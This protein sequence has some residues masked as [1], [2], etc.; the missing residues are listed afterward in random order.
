MK[1][2]FETNTYKRLLELANENNVSIPALANILLTTLLQTDSKN[3]MFYET[4]WHQV[5]RKEG[6]YLNDPTQAKISDI[7]KQFLSKK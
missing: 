6:C 3:M 1:I 2:H 5:N 7:V 4:N